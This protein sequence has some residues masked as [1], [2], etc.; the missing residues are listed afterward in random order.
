MGFSCVPNYK[1]L[2]K[3]FDGSHTNT[4]VRPLT[5]GGL[6]PNRYTNMLDKLDKL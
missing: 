6:L 2:E 3:I 5:T 4:A 1:I